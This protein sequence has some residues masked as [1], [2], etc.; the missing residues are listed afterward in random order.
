[1]LI[2]VSPE[3]RRDL[4]GTKN[5]I[6]LGLVN[7]ASIVT[8]L[9]ALEQVPGIIAFPIQAAGGM[10]LNTLWA[11]WVWEERFAGR[12]I[13]GMVIAVLGLVLVNVT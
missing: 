9:I 5:G 2:F 12:T 3:W 4:S 10:V 6:R 1:M 7:V 8:Y 11:A 13:L